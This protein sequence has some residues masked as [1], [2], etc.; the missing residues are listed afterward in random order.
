MPMKSLSRAL[1]VLTELS[2][3]GH[4]S[5]LSDISNS[6]GLHKSTVHRMLATFVEHGLVRRDEANRY[7]VGLAALEL[8]RAAQGEVAPDGTVELALAALH[9]ATGQTA[10]Y[11]LPRGG[12]MAYAA[13]V[14]PA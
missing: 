2:R 11:A 12:H 10:T 1:T 4:P 5:T 7:V 6:V 8:A 13:V 9:E 14:G 3:Q